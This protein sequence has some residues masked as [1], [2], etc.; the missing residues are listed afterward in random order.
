MRTA[1]RSE[2]LSGISFLLTYGSQ[3]LNLVLVAHTLHTEPGTHVFLF[4]SLYKLTLTSNI[5]I[6]D[7]TPV[8]E[9]LGQTCF[10]I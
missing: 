2:K 1:C 10:V 3:G 6:E 5:A 7:L 9:G 4:V 8:R